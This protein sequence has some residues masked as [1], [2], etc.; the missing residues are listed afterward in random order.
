[1]RRLAAIAAGLVALAVAAAPAATQQAAPPPTIAPGVLTVALDLPSDGFQVGAVAGSQV[2]FARGL[3]VDLAKAV[4]ARMGLRAS[5]VN[6]ASFA[7]IVAPGPKP[8][9]VAFAQVSI[10]AGRRAAIDYTV[11][12]LQVDQGVL[13]RRGLAPRP[14][15]LAALARL[16]LCVQA[17][18]TGAAVVA[19]RVKPTRR[20]TGYADVTALVQ[21]LATGRCDAVVYDAPSLAVLRSEVPLRVGPMAGVIPTAE[22]YGGV[23]ADASA[24]TPALNVAL[25][26]LL[27]DGTV[28]ALATKW[29]SID[30][31]SLKPLR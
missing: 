19:R 31:T 12:Y 23:T 26:A 1:M 5:F 21:G 13:L 27:A 6:S 28:S 7:D 20:A 15:T 24:L 9:D 25:R 16:R 29:L 14:R 2:V 17:K 18:T 11:P 30:V 22:S 3:E 10:L 8:W 4:A